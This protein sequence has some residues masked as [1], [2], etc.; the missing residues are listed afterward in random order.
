MNN[1][2]N[3]VGVALRFGAEW[4]RKAAETFRRNMLSPSSG[5]YSQPEDGDSGCICM[6]INM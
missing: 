4:F 1:E 5:L 3:C 2:T 6:Y